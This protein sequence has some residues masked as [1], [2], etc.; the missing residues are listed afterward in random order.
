[1]LGHCR[2]G[3]KLQNCRRGRESRVNSASVP[4]RFVAADGFGAIGPGECPSIHAQAM[5]GHFGVSPDFDDH[6]DGDYE[7]ERVPLDEVFD[8]FGYEEGFLQFIPREFAA[9]SDG[10][11]L[12]RA[13]QDGVNHIVV[14]QHLDLIDTRTVPDLPEEFLGLDSAVGRV[15]NTTLSIVV[16]AAVCASIRVQELLYN[17]CAVLQV[18]SNCRSC[19]WSM[20]MN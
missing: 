16:R 6:A 8:A 19:L 13:L 15:L 12:Q 4:T 1:M 18:A 17:C 10:R 20:D 3:G 9:V 5:P 2:R 14:T 11:Q 7:E